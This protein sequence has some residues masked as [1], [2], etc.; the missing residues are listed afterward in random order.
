MNLFQW[1]KNA[2]AGLRQPAVPVPE[3][4]DRPPVRRRYRFYGLVQG[5]GFR[6]E[7]MRIASQLSLVGWVK[8][9]YDGSVT[10]EIEGAPNYIDAFMLAMR[11]VPRFGI[12]EVTTED[13]PLL[14]TETDFRLFY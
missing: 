13:L 14:G 9:E 7:A 2:G 1:M 8:N 4:P 10:A 12:R 3:A 5:V 6:Y 11:A